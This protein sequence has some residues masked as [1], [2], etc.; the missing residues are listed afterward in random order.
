MFRTVQDVVVPA[1]VDEVG[2]QHAPPRAL[3]DQLAV[4]TQR[5]FQ[6]G[7]L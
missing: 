7:N 1:K 3:D 5:L 6:I 2:A 4:K